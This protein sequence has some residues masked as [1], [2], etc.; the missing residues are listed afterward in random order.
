MVAIVTS[1]QG[2]GLGSA[3]KHISPP[4][5]LLYTGQRD[6]RMEDAPFYQSL[7]YQPEQAGAICFH[8]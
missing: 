4:C 8:C 7:Q 5:W 1:L 2:L 6:H 3:L